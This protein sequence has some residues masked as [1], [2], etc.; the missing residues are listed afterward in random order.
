[1]G[2]SSMLGKMFGSGVT[3][4]ATG[5]AD[6]VDRFVETADEKEAAR[7]IRAKILQDPQRW[8]MEVN[9][10][11]AAHRSVFVAGWRPW[12]GWIL[13]TSL[14]L[15][16]LPQFAMAAVI[17]SRACWMAL[18]VAQVTGVAVVL[19][20]YPISDISGLTEL[21]VGMLGLGALRTVEKALNISK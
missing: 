20:A 14:G 8:Q 21:V 2:L 17:W 11:G 10:V 19:P 7:V 6:V 16:Y 12:I 15:Y 9:K 1:M 4:V 5:L 18:E 3:E 13:G